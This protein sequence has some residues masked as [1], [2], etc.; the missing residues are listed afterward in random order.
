MTLLFVPPSTT[1]STSAERRTLLRCLR[2]ATRLP[3][4]QYAVGSYPNRDPSSQHSSQNRRPDNGQCYQ[5]SGWARHRGNQG[6]NSASE[7]EYAV[8]LALLFS[9]EGKR[10]A[11]STPPTLNPVD[12][13]PYLPHPEALAQKRLYFTDPDRARLRRFLKRV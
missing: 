1:K 5:R 7:P 13:T 12:K 3:V 11:L 8:V 6:R 10:R 2:A 4:S 9:P